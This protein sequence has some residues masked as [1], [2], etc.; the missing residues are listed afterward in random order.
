[1][2]G[3]WHPGEMINVDGVWELKECHW[4]TTMVIPTV[5]QS[6]GVIKLLEENTKKK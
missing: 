3:F 1:M 6:C 4:T 5:I 2:L